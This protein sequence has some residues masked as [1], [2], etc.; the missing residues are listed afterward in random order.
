M[1]VPTRSHSFALAVESVSKLT[2]GRYVRAPYSPMARVTPF[3]RLMLL[4]LLSPQ[5]SAVSARIAQAQVAANDGGLSIGPVVLRLGATED[6]VLLVLRRH[7]DLQRAEYS[8]PAFG[9]YVIVAKGNPDNVLGSVR[10]RSGTLTLAAKEWTPEDKSYSGADVAEIIYKVMFK[11]EQQG[12]VAC[13]IRTISSVQSVG[14]SG[15]ELRQSEIRCG[16]RRLDISL[17]WQAGQAWIQAT[18]SIAEQGE[19]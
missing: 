15:L 18:E 16:H 6:S 4:L 12:D 7:Y 19:P 13:T 9:D 17:S 8:T 11:F 3:L 2:S 10:F 14:P 1:P 5:V